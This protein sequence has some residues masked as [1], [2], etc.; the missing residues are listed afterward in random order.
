[1]PSGISNGTAAELDSAETGIFCFEG[2]RGLLVRVEACREGGAVCTPADHR[3]CVALF[4]QA[5]DQVVC[6]DRDGRIIYATNRLRERFP[7][8]LDSVDQTDKSACHPVIGAVLRNEIVRA[9][10]KI[11]WSRQ[12]VI[13]VLDGD[14][15]LQW[16]VTYVPEM[17][18][19]GTVVCVACV[20]RDL[21][22]RSRLEALLVKRDRLAAVGTLTDSLFHEMKNVQAPAVGFLDLVLAESG[23]S[24]KNDWRIQRA[25][26]A[27][28]R[29]Q[30]LTGNLLS[31][32]R[33]GS[34]V[35]G[36]TQWPEVLGPVLRL[37]EAEFKQLGVDFQLEPG[38][39]A[40]MRIAESLLAQVALNLLLNAGDAVR[41]TKT[42]R[43]R[44]AWG[45]AENRWAFL[46]VTDT[47][48][49]FGPE[50]RQRLFDPF[51]T[52]K[53][54]GGTGLGLAVCRLIVEGHGGRIEADGAPGR[55]A[56]FTVWLPAV[57]D[58]NH[59]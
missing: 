39:P 1:M 16:S 37:L 5:G 47:G 15:R 23:L 20:L 17:D 31:F 44:A 32:V 3:Q 2:D 28:C 49:G 30:L 55:G 18:Q 38:A 4:E 40:V 29:A 36:R 19:N 48:C 34:S 52:T 25:R 11:G 26:E 6:V 8:R 59:G 43:V 13:E 53:G 45:V 41:E 57:E 22:E 58:A 42:R 56:R 51:F 14:C 50:V 12:A 35:E 33:E 7:L 10:F 21:D 27:L 54:E 24:P 46:M 9:V